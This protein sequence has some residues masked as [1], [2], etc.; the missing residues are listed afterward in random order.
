MGAKVKLA[1]R[2]AFT[3]DGDSGAMWMQNRFSFRFH[4]RLFDHYDGVIVEA[5]DFSPKAPDRRFLGKLFEKLAKRVSVSEPAY[6]VVEYMETVQKPSSSSSAPVSS[7]APTLPKETT[8]R[9]PG[10]TMIKEHKVKM[11]SYSIKTEGS[12]N[13]RGADTLVIVPIEIG[14][15][16]RFTNGKSLYLEIPVGSVT[17]VERYSEAGTKG[18]GKVL[19]S[20]DDGSP[21]SVAFDMDDDKVKELVD[22]IDFLRLYEPSYLDAIDFEYNFGGQWLTS[23]LYSRALYLA[24]GEQLLWSDDGFNWLGFGS[25]QWFKAL[26][27]FRVFYYDFKAHQCNSMS[28]PMVESVV[29]ANKRR[30]SRSHHQGEIQ[31]RDT[32]LGK[33]SQTQ[34][35]GET[36][37]V[38]VGDV[39]FMHGGKPLVTFQG[40]EDPDGMAQMARS[41]VEQARKNTRMAAKE[42]TVPTAR[43][44]L[45]SQPQGAPCKKCQSYNPEGSAFCN[46]CGARL[47]FGCGK[48]GHANPEGSKFCNECGEK[49]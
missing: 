1:S 47:N 37:S 6:A 13:E 18:N 3:I 36:E 43:T 10:R 27:N 44:T 22:E 42:E 21:H 19:I 2:E 30:E 45:P 15:K 9:S 46:K 17:S 28:L 38:S 7:D 35:Y 12:G 33:Y 23:K 24:N 41:A 14:N 31:G 48:C 11:P 20:Y 39:L 25:Y 8:A 26:T 34:G 49:L 40:V 29:V 16:I 5:F 32:S 4:A